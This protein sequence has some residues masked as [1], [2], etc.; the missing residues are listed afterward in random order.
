[1]NKPSYSTSRRYLWISFALSW[2]VILV[3]AIGAIRGSDQAVAFG[4]IAVPAMVA[5]IAAILGIHRFAGSMDF[6]NAALAK[7]NDPEGGI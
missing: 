1:M 6:R 4:A 7:S 5:L 3:L 2:S